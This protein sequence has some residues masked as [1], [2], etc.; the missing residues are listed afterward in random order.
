[1]IILTGAGGFIGSVILKYLN[2]Q[3]I[4]DIIIVDDLPS[5]SQFRNLVE[6]Q[7]LKILSS[8]DALELTDSIDA[9]IHFGANSSTLETN[10]KSIYKTNIVSTRNW[11]NFAK[12]QNAKFIFASSAAV[13]GNGHGPLN[14]YAFSKQSSENEITNGVILRLFNVYGPNEYHKGRMASTIYHWY[15][16]LQTDNKIK[17][18]ENSDCY[19]RDFI[20]VEDV[21][22]VV[23]FFLNNYKTG[24]YD[25]GTGR[26]TSFQYIANFLLHKTPKSEIE[27]IS[28]PLDLQK[29]YQ[30]NTVADTTN[31]SSAG[32]NCKELLSIES[33]ILKYL[34]YLKTNSYY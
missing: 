21:A 31:L 10:W 1:M 28:M 27:Y 30:K 2:L 19:Y 33:G 25:L 26:S 4:N 20:Y 32:Y 18:F 3:N 5:S 9:V 14:H 7:Y 17:V 11:H 16:Q 6:K 15:Q 23:H 34:D 24:T 12:K 29:Q 22:K 13:Y 8:R